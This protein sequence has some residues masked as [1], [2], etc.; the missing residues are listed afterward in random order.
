MLKLI[1]Y[2][3]E[4]EFDRDTALFMAR[5]YKKHSVKFQIVR[6]PEN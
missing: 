2:G 5:H 3:V 4:R 6:H 1:A